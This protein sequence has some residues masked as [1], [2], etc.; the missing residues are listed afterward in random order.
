MPI[1]NITQIEII[2]IDKTLRLRKFDYKYD[3]ALR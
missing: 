1:K 3:F 2:N